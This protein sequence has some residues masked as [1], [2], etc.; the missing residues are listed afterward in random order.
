VSESPGGYGGA[1]GDLSTP[2]QGILV[3]GESHFVAPVAIGAISVPA[4]IMLNV[5]GAARVDVLEIQGADVAEK[6]PVSE[7]ETIAPG[8]VMEIDPENA[9]KLRIA[10]GA[11]NRRVAGVVSGA[12]DLPVGA[13]LGHLPG[14]E[15]APPIALGGRVWVS[16]DA[17]GG[18]I[19]VGDLLTTSDTPGH[20]MVASDQDRANGAVLGKAMSA[21]P[22]GGT[23]LVLVLVNLQ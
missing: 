2:G 12:G 15:D 7:S 4:G 19:G 6:F 13:V 21:M 18:A 17:S 8:T 5:E 10:R 20:A 9:G 11:Y 16:C 14:H 1:F 22:E 23:G 3:V